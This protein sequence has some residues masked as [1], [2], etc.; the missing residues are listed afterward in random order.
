MSMMKRSIFIS[1]LILLVFTVHTTVDV[2]AQV[3]VKGNIE[4]QLSVNGRIMDPS[5]LP[6]NLPNHS[7]QGFSM[8]SDNPFPMRVNINDIVY[9]VWRNKIVESCESDN[10]S[11]VVEIEPDLLTMWSTGL[12]NKVPGHQVDLSFL[13]NSFKGNG[14][15]KDLVI[16]YGIPLKIPP[17]R[18]DGMIDINVNVET[19]LTGDQ[20]DIFV[21]RTQQI[22]SLS[23]SQVMV[24][25]DQYL[26]TDMQQMTVSSGTNDL[27]VKYETATGQTTS[28][29]S[30][31]IIVPDYDLS[32]VQLSDIM[33]A[34]SVAETKNDIPL[35]ENEMVRNDFSILPAPRNI[36]SIEWP[37][38]LY[39][40]IY[41]LTLNTQG[42]T[43][44]DLEITL[45]SKS[46]HRGIRRVARSI[47]RR[48]K[49]GVSVSYKGSGLELDESLYQILDVNDQKPGLYTIN[50]IV[51]DN[52]TGEESERTRD[53]F[54]ERWGAPCND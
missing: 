17:N 16:N 21:E 27:V 6:E 19:F 51:R 18:S 53:L 37:V 7:P 52:E 30:Q 34:Y 22:D 24:F 20:S 5:N 14:Q 25:P 48:S 39:F 49:K 46:T 13:T 40:E 54:L 26:W 47:F 2:S 32:G 11:Y 31:E 45:K 8:Y 38:Y 9:E 12:N 4:G 36:Y 15:Q 29:D 33:L 43:D 28:T 41:G 50:L 3:Y 44:Y 23:A 35:S 1:I 42:K 10:V